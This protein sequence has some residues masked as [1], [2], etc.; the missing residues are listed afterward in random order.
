[1][2]WTTISCF[3]NAADCS[4]PPQSEFKPLSGKNH[5]IFS[6]PIIANFSIA[7]RLR[8]RVAKPVRHSRKWSPGYAKSKPKSWEDI[9]TNVVFFQKR[10]IAHQ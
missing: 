2:K 6:R 4:R 5:K 7:P 9:K 3:D 1:M 10:I 8:V